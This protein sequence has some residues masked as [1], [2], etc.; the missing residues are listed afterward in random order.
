MLVHHANKDSIRQFSSPDNNH[1]KCLELMTGLSETITDTIKVICGW[2]RDGLWVG[3]PVADKMLPA[4]VLSLDFLPLQPFVWFE[5]VSFPRVRDLWFSRLDN[6]CIIA[7]K[8]SEELSTGLI[9]CRIY[10]S[11]PSHRFDN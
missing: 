11:M 1:Q 3:M 5:P 8:S 2:R 7:F 4:F 9:V 6:N 10:L